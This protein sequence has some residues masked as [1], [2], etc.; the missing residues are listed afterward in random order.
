MVDAVGLEFKGE[1]KVEVFRFG[2]KAFVM[3]GEVGLWSTWVVIVDIVGFGFGGM[4]VVEMV[5]CRGVLMMEAFALWF[6]GVVTVD[7]VGIGFKGTAPNDKPTR[8]VAA[9]AVVRVGLSGVFSDGVLVS[10]FMV[11]VV[12]VSEATSGPVESG[13]GDTDTVF[14]M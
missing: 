6:R 4:V 14:V 12:M 13:G 5:G 9:I 8:G 10:V 3:V 1:D 7:I 2:L 11:T